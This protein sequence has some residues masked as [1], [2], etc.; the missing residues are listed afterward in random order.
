MV[1]EIVYVLEKVY[2]IKREEIEENIVDM[3]EYPN[4]Q[5]NDKSVLKFALKKYTESKYEH[6]K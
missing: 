1:A 3:I 5:T 4:I 6:F 2:N